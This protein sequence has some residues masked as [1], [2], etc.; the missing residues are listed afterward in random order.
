MEM[1]EDKVNN[2]GKENLNGRDIGCS[3]QSHNGTSFIYFCRKGLSPER[4]RVY[5]G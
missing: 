5:W 4:E 3:V 1:E 2:N